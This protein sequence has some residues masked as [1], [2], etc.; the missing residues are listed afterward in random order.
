MHRF[1]KKTTAYIT[2]PELEAIRCGRCISIAWKTIRSRSWRT[3]GPKLSGLLT[4]G[5][6]DGRTLHL[7]LGVDDLRTTS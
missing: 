6:S 7:T 3:Y 2:T 1:L 4:D 5:A